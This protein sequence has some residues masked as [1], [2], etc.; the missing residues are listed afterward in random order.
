MDALA[1]PAFITV[2]RVVEL[3]LARR[4]TRR[5]LARGGREEAAG[6]YPLMVAFHA[7]WLAAMW[8]LSWQATLVPVWT[9]LFVALQGV[10]IWILASLGERWTTRIVVVDAPLVRRGPY[11]WL[12]H[13]NYA[14]VVA[15]VAVVPLALGA[16]LAALVVSLPHLALIRLRVTA[17]EAALARAGHG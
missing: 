14:L 4:N 10:R 1:L 11:R 17:E 6:H 7:A 12:K 5:L 2:Q 13:P 9:A 8:G 3:A 15:E 16:P